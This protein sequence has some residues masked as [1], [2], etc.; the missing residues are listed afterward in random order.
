MLLDFGTDYVAL[1]A[2]V[3][4]ISPAERARDPNIGFFEERNPT[5]NRGTELPC[6]ADCDYGSF[7]QSLFI[8]PTKWIRRHWFG[9]LPAGLDKPVIGQ[10]KPS[11]SA[12][13][14][15]Q[16]HVDQA[17]EGLTPKRTS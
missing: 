4:E 1:K 9:A 11:A 14:A 16:W 2:G 13:D 7:L 15:Q 8:V 12:S 6:L 17:D 10:A 5:W 3:A